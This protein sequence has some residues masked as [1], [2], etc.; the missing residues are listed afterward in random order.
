MP[1][2]IRTPYSF[3]FE[4]D[5][6]FTAKSESFNLNNIKNDFCIWGARE[7]TGGGELPIHIRYAI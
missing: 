7:G 6:S 3:K 2:K 1:T 4:D 5:R